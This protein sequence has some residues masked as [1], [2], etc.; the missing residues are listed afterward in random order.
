MEFI[1]FYSLKFTHLFLHRS[2]VDKMLK[3]CFLGLGPHVMWHSNLIFFN[4]I[5]SYLSIICCILDHLLDWLH[6][7]YLF[8]FTGL[9]L[10]NV[11]GP[12]YLHAKPLTVK[13][14]VTGQVTCWSVCWVVCD[15]TISQISP[16]TH[17][18]PLPFSLSLYRPS[19]YVTLDGR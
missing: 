2:R 15:S 7:M 17:F 14:K 10:F 4:L 16:V 19:Q 6:D 1:L 12:G 3:L 8:C 9:S 13:D 18:F 11:F 5:S